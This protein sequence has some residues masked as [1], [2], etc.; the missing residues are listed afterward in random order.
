MDK[1]YWRTFIKNCIIG[2]IIL[3]LLYGVT[4]FVTRSRKKE[5]FN[6]SLPKVRVGVS[7]TVKNPHKI[8]DW[9]KYHLNINFAKVYIV[10]DDENENYNIISDPR[11]VIFKN[12]NEW[13]NEIAQLTHMQNFI[14]D[15]KEVMSRQIVN[16]ANVRKHAMKDNIDWL[17]HIDGD[18]LFYPEETSLDD[19]FI[20]GV[21]TINFQN[22]E[23][24]PKRDN[25][26]NCFIDGIDFKINPGIFNAYSNGKSAVRVKS[27]AEI[28]G[29]H[30]FQGGNK[31]RSNIGKILHYPSCNFDEY[32]SKYKILGKF[33]DKWWDEVQIPFKFHTESR[34]IITECSAREQKGEKHACETSVRQYYNRSNVYNSNI[35][36]NDVKIIEFVKNQLLD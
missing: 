4:I 32:I 10:F 27:S 14:Q 29:V 25:Y 31:I 5:N 9:I 17:L 35:N 30:D 16:F 36:P 19:I 28:A 7:T 2:L 33:N 18:E 26:E 15:K 23:M 6:M 3:F 13:K 11:V 20:N 12:N 34:D 21:D 1:E 8:N 22:L 24:I